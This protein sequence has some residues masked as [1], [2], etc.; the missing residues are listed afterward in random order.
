MSILFRIKK[1]LFGSYPENPFSKLAPAWKRACKR[2]LLS[3]CGKEALLSTSTLKAFTGLKSHKYVHDSVP[4]PPNLCVGTQK[5]AAKPLQVGRRPA[6]PNGHH[7][8]SI[9]LF[10]ILDTKL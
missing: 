1:Q 3:I 4:P 8:L 5:W 6:L 2:E 10:Y 7:A 9:A